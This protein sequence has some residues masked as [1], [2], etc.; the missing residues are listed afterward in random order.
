MYRG[1]LKSIFSELIR[2]NRLILV[3]KFCIKEPKTKML[4]NQLNRMDV[5]NDIL[6]L[7]NDILDKNLFLAS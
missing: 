5:K 4:I 6:I 7:V 3:S 1:A 2:K